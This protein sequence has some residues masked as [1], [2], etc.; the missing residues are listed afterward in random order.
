MHFFVKSVVL[1]KSVLVFTLL[2][3]FCTT[4]ASPSLADPYVVV[5]NT[6][7]PQP[8]TYPAAIY[9]GNGL[10]YILGG[11]VRE[12]S[13]LNTIYRFNTSDE[14]ITLAGIL[15]GYVY[16]GDCVFYP[17]E[18]AI[19]HF[20]GS[21]NVPNVLR[22]TLS[23]EL[24]RVLEIIT[25]GTINEDNYLLFTRGAWDSSRKKAYFLGKPSYYHPGKGFFE[26]DPLNIN[27]PLRL[28]LIENV[29]PFDVANVASFFDESSG[30]LYYL[31]GSKWENSEDLDSIYQ[32]D[33]SDSS[34]TLL[35][36]TL[37]YPDDN[38][39]LFWDKE[40]GIAYIFE[41]SKITHSGLMWFK[42]GTMEVGYI[43][44]EHF[45]EYTAFRFGLAW[46]WDQ[47]RMYMFGG[48]YENWWEHATDRIQYIQL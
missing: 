44:L 42:P 21:W 47:R 18:N 40:N 46:D 41:D 17:E 11:S 24:D 13:H 9:V 34:L 48:N 14:S 15:P 26:F 12:S 43:P 16:T 4:L 1:I 30:K 37:P 31:G 38:G 5:L 20:G 29:W 7:L 28:K 36:V 27:V 39:H 6:T 19:F 32:F 8:F 10:A 25:E 35:N 23:P 45:M 33:P 3:N 2:G 22:I